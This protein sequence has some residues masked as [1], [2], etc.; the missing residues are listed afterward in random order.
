[1]NRAF[2]LIEL[3]VVMVIIVVIMGLVM[4]KG[5]KLV[6][7]FENEMNR[8]QEFH[9]FKLNQAYC[10]IKVEAKTVKFEDKIYKI[11]KKGVVTED[12]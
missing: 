10:F 12:E 5:A 9:D 7:G 11:S 6:S 2:T 4:P 1:M 3:L 8:V